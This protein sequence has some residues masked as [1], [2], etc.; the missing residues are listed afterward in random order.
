MSNLTIIRRAPDPE[1][2]E[3]H[4]HAPVSIADRIRQM[5]EARLG[6]LLLLLATA[7]AIAWANVS[8]AS[9]HDFWD[10]ELTFGIADLH[11]AFTLHALVND[12]LMAIFFFTVGLEVRR[13]PLQT[14]IPNRPDPTSRAILDELA[15]LGL[16]DPEERD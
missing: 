2:P 9:Y 3:E 13:T 7:A 5:G 6:A 8:F 4:E 1:R 10:T 14:Y 16:A 15:A 11:V 12:A